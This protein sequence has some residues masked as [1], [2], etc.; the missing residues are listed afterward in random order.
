MKPFLYRLSKLSLSCLLVCVS[1]FAAYAAPDNNGKPTRE[2]KN[3]LVI[4]A[5]NEGAPWPQMFIA[6]IIQNV[7]TTREYVVKT[8]NLNMTY[9]T[10]DSLLHRMMDGFFNKFD[11]RRPDGIVMVGES[12]FVLVDQIK[13]RWGDGPMLLIGNSDKVGPDK[14]YI[15]SDT[16]DDA[17]VEVTSLSSLRSKYDFTYIEAPFMYRQTLDLIV[18]MNPNIKKIVFASDALSVNRHLNRRIRQYLK[19][20]YPKI[21]YEWLVADN[22]N[23]SKLM[24]YLMSR[25]NKMGFLFSSWFYSKLD[26]NGIP[27]LVEGDYRVIPQALQPVYALRECYIDKGIIGGYYPNNEIIVDKILEYIHSMSH[28]VKMNS[29]PFFY[30]PDEDFRYVINYEQLL[31]DGYKVAD[32]PKDTHFINKPKSLWESY[33]WQIVGVAV[34]LLAIFGLLM[35][36]ANMIR[37][38]KTVNSLVQHMPVAYAHAE[39]K[40]KANG[41]LATLKYVN[42]NSAFQTLAHP[43]EGSESDDFF[44]ADYIRQ[45]ISTALREGRSL[46]FTHYFKDTDK[47]YEFV[48]VPD[49][50]DGLIDI[51]GVDIT[52]R[53]KAEKS[54]RDSQKQ[55]ELTLSMAHIIPWRWELKTQRIF[56]E[57]DRMLT[58]LEIPVLPGS[59]VG[60]SIID[61]SE[62]FQHV[63][64]ED[65]ARVRQTYHELVDGNASYV[66]ETFRIVSKKN[67]KDYID[68]MEVNATVDETDEMGR[69]IS[70]VGSLLVITERKKQEVALIQAKDRA[71]ESDR[72]KSAFLA[73]MSHEIRTPLNAIVGFSNLLAS[74]VEPEKKEK[75][76]GIIENNNQ[77][78]LQLINDVLDLAKIEANTLDFVKEKVDLNELMHS[79]Q[80]TVKLRTKPGVALNCNLGAHQM[81]IVT[82]P[83]R[84][85]Q[86]LINL[87]TNACK[88]TD[89]GAITFGY[90]V[91]G[92]NLYFYVRDTGMGIAPEKQ[93]SVFQRFTKLNNFVQGTGLGLAISQ[94][95]V[96][97]FGGEIGVESEGEGFGSTFWFTMPINGELVEDNSTPVSAAAARPPRAAV[98]V[99]TPTAATARRPVTRSAVPGPRSVTPTPRAARPAQPTAPA[100]P[101]AP[102][103]APAATPTPAVAP[104]PAPVETEAPRTVAPAAPAPAA[105]APRTVAPAPAAPAP[106]EAPRSVAPV[107]AAPAEPEKEVMRRDQKLTLL[108]AEDNESNYLLFESILGS[109][110]NLVH[111]W[112]GR[113]AI[114]L[115]KE[116][117]PKVIIMDINMPNMDGYEATK[118]IRKLSTS[119]PIIAVTAYAFASDKERIMENGFNS[120][121][122]KPVNAGKL[123]SEL[124][125][126]VENAFI[127]L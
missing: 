117:N 105:E 28:G 78:L 10:S 113:E 11:N 102:A 46:S 35:A 67:G 33:Q 76:V 71:S 21:D 85:S 45:L 80:D 120:Y 34:N 20:N 14:F 74:T 87:L 62:F 93:A 97:K 43:A 1:A 8:E 49:K 121:V 24:D 4:N 65:V 54:V 55:L 53:S 112:D 95:I 72:L 5:Y 114:V 19:Y 37:S 32:C 13:K 66:Q 60:L 47:Y 39:A 99:A 31:R 68:W 26:I 22:E 58:H 115:F 18:Q 25:D 124:R 56:C 17:D 23:N 12:A 91:R 82:D 96:K 70:L 103:P 123:I 38:A 75:Y 122:S 61:S 51:F 29:L 104:A 7:A 100:S 109:E 59:R 16:I 110:Y 86:V 63:H 106:A 57:E 3:L 107:S 69:A 36:R 127:F 126:A 73:N 64:R 6:P 9:V 101:A 119:V 40:V 79:I 125:A 81:E 15:T 27:Q 42:G 44:K 84:L 92:E 108:V 48:I 41:E 30:L 116:H 52:Q 98:P 77:L 83:N 2:F 118:E 89:R 90:D 94:T 111:A 50:T 88:F